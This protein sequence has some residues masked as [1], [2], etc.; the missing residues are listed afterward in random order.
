M[1]RALLCV[2][3]LF[4]GCASMAQATIFGKVQGIVHDPQHRPIVG[5]TVVLKAITSAYTL[6]T[7]TDG[8]GGFSLA[9][10]TVGDYSV[11]VTQQGFDSSMQTVTVNSNSAP[12]LHFQLSLTSVQ[13]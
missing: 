7:Q 10:V 13:Q 1:R 11:T 12:V 6:T 9:A 2:L 3:C 4:L 5:A 8:E